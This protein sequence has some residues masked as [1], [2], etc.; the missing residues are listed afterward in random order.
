MTTKTTKTT[1]TTPTPRQALAYY[2]DE[3]RAIRQAILNSPNPQPSLIDRFQQ[4]NQVRLAI[5]E[6]HGLQTFAAS[7]LAD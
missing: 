4:F 7:L 3:C 1:Q 6:A 2:T 5:A